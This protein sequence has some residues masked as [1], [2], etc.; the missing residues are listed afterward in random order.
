MSIQTTLP[1]GS[2]IL[3]TGAS[4]Y[5]G[6][7]VTKQLLHRG[8]K[9]RGTVRDMGKAEWLSTDSFPKEATNGSLELVIL[10]NINDKNQIQQ[11][12][13]GVA[14]VVHIATPNTFDPDPNETVTQT[15]KF[16]VNLLIAAA[17]EKTVKEFVYTST[18]GAATML[19]AQP[20][21]HFDGTNWNKGARA[22]AWAPPPYTPDRG[23]IAYVQGKVEAEQAFWKFFEENKPTFKGNTVI[24]CTV[25]GPRLHEKS[26]S[27]TSAWLWSIYNNNAAPMSFFPSSIFVDVR[28]VALLH[29]AALLDP[30]IEGARLPAWGYEFNWNDILKILQQLHPGKALPV[31]LDNPGG[32][33]GTADVAQAKHAL[34]Q[35]GGQDDFISLEN[36]VIDTLN[37]PSVSG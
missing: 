27:S 25:F 23:M 11:A 18:I 12:I 20:G 16:V 10:N 1:E 7:H 34:K 4:G 29:V 14:G 19:P 24:V 2:L 22:L 32:F 13:Q 15:V 5:L 33:N 37:G 28:D 17:S 36:G 9:V 8:Y 26:N 21:F 35:W 3:V 6:A 30:S 31:A